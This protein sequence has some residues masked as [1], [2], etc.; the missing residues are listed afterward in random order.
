M[1]AEQFLMEKFG[2]IEYNRGEVYINCIDDLLVDF[3]KMHVKK[4]LVAAANQA[5][6][7]LET[8][9][10]KNDRPWSWTIVDKKS[11]LD[12]YPLTNIQ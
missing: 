10:D 8:S 5:K 6:T 12:A 9:F 4:A 1:T 11:I 3:A 7:D 2:T